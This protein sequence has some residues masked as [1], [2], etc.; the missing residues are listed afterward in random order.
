M[1]QGYETRMILHSRGPARILVA[2]LLLMLLTQVMGD[3][4]RPRWPKTGK[5][6]VPEAQKKRIARGI[7]STY[8]Q[9]PFQQS[10]KMKEYA[11][12]LLTP[13]LLVQE[14][15]CDDIIITYPTE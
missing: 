13:A 1:K 6:H 8:G 14:A 11:D 7:A 15:I 2:A 12:Y 3:N 9:G 5:T 10:L 4:A